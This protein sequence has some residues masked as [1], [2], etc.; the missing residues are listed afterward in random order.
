MHA[1]LV[2]SSMDTTIP[3]APA[4]V[5][6]AADRIW[7]GQL[8]M[9]GLAE[10][11]RSSWDALSRVVALGTDDGTV[12]PTR[13]DWLDL[14]NC[15]RRALATIRS[16]DFEVY[17][18]SDVAGYLAARAADRRG[19]AIRGLAGHRDNAV[20][21]PELFDPVVE[22]AT[23]P[24]ADGQHILSPRWAERTS[25][26]DPVFST[27]GGQ[28]SESYARAYEDHVAG[29]PLLDPLLDAFAFFHSLAPHLARRDEHEGR[30]CQPL[31]VPPHTATADDQE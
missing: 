13:D 8:L 28:F 15:M 12:R 20:H 17:Q 24:D 30:A 31:G 4:S 9:S 22:E 19:M 26:L 25:R 14:V 18:A 2:S 6:I 3:R 23:S 11:I 5:T 21:H 29:R 27:R 1:I 16:L 7:K 10:E